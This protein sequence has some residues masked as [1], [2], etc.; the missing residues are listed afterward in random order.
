M[1]VVTIA[2]NS[3]MPH[4]ERFAQLLRESTPD[5]KL[6]LLQLKSDQ[7][8]DWKAPLG[9]P[10]SMCCAG[11]DYVSSSDPTNLLQYDILRASLLQRFGLREALYMDP[12]VDVV[13]DLSELQDMHTDKALMLVKSPIAVPQVNEHI[14]TLADVRI[15]DHVHYNIGTMYMRKLDNSYSYFQDIMQPLMTSVR[16][17]AAEFMAGTALWN[18]MLWPDL[19]GAW[20]ELPYEYGTLAND[21]D[22]LSKAKVI[23]FSGPNKQMRF[24]WNYDEFPNRIIMDLK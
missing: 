24:C 22:A 3:W 17:K 14:E 4:V 19:R 1:N 21:V 10:L 5:V 16:F 8:E 12:D 2:S 18:A 11:V 9:G 15:L 7:E 6:Y 23:H 20:V 13:G